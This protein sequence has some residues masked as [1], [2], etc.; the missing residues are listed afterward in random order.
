MVQS[1]AEEKIAW[2]GGEAGPTPGDRETGGIASRKGWIAS[3]IATAA[4]SS[5]AWTGKESSARARRPPGSDGG[6][7]GE[8]RRSHR[9]AP[10][11]QGKDLKERTS[12]EAVPADDRTG[13]TL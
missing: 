12:L 9:K 5:I 7:P 11:G 6:A 3:G 13:T 4:V 10:R 2:T 8:A 1:G